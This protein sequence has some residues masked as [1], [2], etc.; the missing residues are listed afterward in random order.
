MQRACAGSN[1]GGAV[2]IIIIILLAIGAALLAWGWAVDRFVANARANLDSLPL[3][4]AGIGVLAI[5]FI[6]LIGYALYRL[7][8]T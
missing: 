6:L 3:A 7:F 4:V 1:A 8:F 2:K 5:D